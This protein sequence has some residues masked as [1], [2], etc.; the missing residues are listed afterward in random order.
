M[1]YFVDRLKANGVSSSKVKQ[2][3]YTIFFSL[4]NLHNFEVV[5]ILE[6]NKREVERQFGELS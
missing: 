4:I 6:I 1:K 2:L 3:N 5:S